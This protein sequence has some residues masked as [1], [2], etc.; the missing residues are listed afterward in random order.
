MA[1][2]KEPKHI[3]RRR[4]NKT[5][6]VDLTVDEQIGLGATVA[7][8]YLEL[9]KLE[10]EIKNIKNDYKSKIEA[11]DEEIKLAIGVIHAGYEMREV[12]VEQVKD[13]KARTIIV[14]R[15]DSEEIDE[16]RTMS[17]EESQMGLKLAEKPKTEKK[18][19]RG[20]QE[21]LKVEPVDPDLLDQAIELIGNTQRATT[22]SVK[23]KLK[24]TVTKAAQI[25]DELEELGIIGPPN[26][27]EPR[28]IHMDKIPE[29]KKK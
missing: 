17:E 19:K 25:M 18:P 7:D 28:L 13:F 24:V 9:S 23:R 6:K 14:T 5:L 27:S 2:K 26:G 12:E 1:K 21:K 15:L 20:E 4:Y 3:E 8:K 22:A 11:K 16:S 29:K 10:G